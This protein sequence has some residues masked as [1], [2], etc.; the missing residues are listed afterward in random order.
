M[1][2]A[3]NP[4]EPGGGG[5]WSAGC[6]SGLGGGAFLAFMK[7]EGGAVGFDDFTNGLGGIDFTKGDGGMLSSE[8][9]W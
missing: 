3:P 1:G 9:G 2:T 5:V 4:G 6:K 7:G 8:G